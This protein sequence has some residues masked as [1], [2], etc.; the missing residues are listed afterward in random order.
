MHELAEIELLDL[1]RGEPPMRRVESTRAIPLRAQRL[2]YWL[3]LSG[4]DGTEGELRV[5]VDDDCRVDLRCG[6][7]CFVDLR[8]ERSGNFS[9]QRT[10]LGGTREVVEG[11]LLFQPGSM[12]VRVVHTTLPPSGT[13][14]Q[15]TY[16]TPAE[17]IPLKVL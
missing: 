12:R 6:G 11:L 14:T 1:N 5:R 2:S 17:A 9:A 10:G 15:N 8:V 3:T 7:M 13:A 4:D 16:D